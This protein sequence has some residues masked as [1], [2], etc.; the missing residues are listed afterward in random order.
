VGLGV[1]ALVGLGVGT[2]VGLGVG[3]GVGASAV[4]GAS[5]HTVAPFPFLLLFDLHFDRVAPVEALLHLE[6]PGTQQPLQAHAGSD[7]TRHRHWS[8]VVHLPVFLCWELYL[9]ELA[10]K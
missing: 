6:Y 5:H 1:G 9:S 10:S 3:A 8:E 7:V 2:L 4:G